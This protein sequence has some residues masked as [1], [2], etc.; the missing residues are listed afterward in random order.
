[1]KKSLITALLFILAMAPAALAAKKSEPV[2]TD[3]EKWVDLAYRISAPVLE[4]M[5]RGELRKNMDLELSPNWDGRDPGV[6][7]MECFGRLMAGIT[8]WLA[9]PD[10]DTDEGKKRKQL[11]EWAIDAYKNAVDPESPDYLLWGGSHPQP[12]V[13]AAYLAESFMRAPEATWQQLDTL[14][15]RRYIECFKGLRRHRPAY[16]NW[17]LFRG[18]IEAFLLTVEPESADNFIFTTVGRKIDEWYLGDGMYGD[19]PELALDNYNSYV[20]HPMYIEML[21]AVENNRTP[22][23]RWVSNIPSELAVKRMQRYNQFIERLIS[24][25]G[26]YP[27]FGRSVVYRLGAFQTLAMSA[28]KYGWPSGLT[29]G[30]VRSALTK[31]MENMFADPGNFTPNGYLALGYAGHQPDLANS[32]TNNGSLYIT[33]TMFMPLGLPADHPFWTDPAE[34]W[35][36]KR[37]WSGREFPIDGHVSLKK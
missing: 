26:T 35:T 13:D 32:Y 21:E 31:V 11:R 28:W 19:G 6:T 34:D 18:L 22:S 2:K 4:N 36:Q 23:N 17:L 1:M 16:N 20:I 14:T 9:L 27:A 3:R 10:D 8:P 25:E 33:S 12:L 5:S 24:P 7:Y 29:N 30:S 37:A 15:Q